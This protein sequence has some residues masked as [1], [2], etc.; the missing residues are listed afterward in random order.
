MFSSTRTRIICGTLALAAMFTSATCIAQD[1]EKRITLQE[2][3]GKAETIKLIIPAGKMLVS[4][5]TGST[6]T[7]ELTASCQ[8]KKDKE[9]CAKLLKEL[10]WAQKLGPVA[11]FGL[12]PSDISEYNDMNIQVKFSVPKDKK[13]NVSLSAGDLR[14][15]GTSACL[16]AEVHAGQI[17]INLKEAQLASAELVSR[18]GDVHMITSKGRVDGNRSLL[19][20]ANLEWNK[21]A[22]ACHTEASVLAGE[23]QLKLD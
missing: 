17:Q 19:V 23:V 9:K 12:S 4:G 18:V 3:S 11:E 6:V 16:D 10:A 1:G 7:A 2:N 21:G 22:G 13:L 8:P 14:I 15:E 5:T 20:G